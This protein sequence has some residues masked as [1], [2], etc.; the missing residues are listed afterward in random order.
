MGDNMQKNEGNRNS[1]NSS[2]DSN[3]DVFHIG[4]RS[5]RKTKLGL[6]E[7]EVRSYVEELISQRDTAVKRQE[8]LAA[9]TEL[10]EKTVIDANNLSQSMMK[11]AADQAKAEAEKIRV[12]AEQEVEQFVKARKAEAKTAADKEAEAIK[13]EAQRQAG[14]VRDQQLDGIRAE[15][16]GLAQKLKNDLIADLE[17]MK[18]LW[19]QLVLN[20]NRWKLSAMPRPVLLLPIT[21]IK[22]LPF[23]TVKR[24]RCL[25]MSRG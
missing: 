11:K 18:K 20:L 4:D 12:R 14:L 5:F 6:A 22:H 17:N 10:A 7:E 19:P 24:E 16:A 2:S 25:T 9:L 21:G 3:E 8:H 13:A 23:P 1:S 15:A